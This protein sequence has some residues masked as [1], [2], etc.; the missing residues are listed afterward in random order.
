MACRVLGGGAL[1]TDLPVV[2]FSANLNGKGPHRRWKNQARGGGV[3]GRAEAVPDSTGLWPLH[4]FAHG[5]WGDRGRGAT[6]LHCMGEAGSGTGG[7][8]PG[9]YLELFPDCSSPGQIATRT[10]NYPRAGAVSPGVPSPLPWR[11][12]SGLVPTPVYPSSPTQGQVDREEWRPQTEGAPRLSERGRVVASLSHSCP[13]SQSQQF[14]KRLHWGL[15]AKRF[16]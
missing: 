14:P 12:S 11:P 6:S 15:N 8:F 3:R 2:S 5:R 13:G 9:Q 4:C 10:D 16:P 7:S 1:P